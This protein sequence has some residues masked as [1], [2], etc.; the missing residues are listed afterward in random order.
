MIDPDHLPAMVGIPAL[1]AYATIPALCVL[2]LTALFGLNDVRAQPWR[3][4]LTW[5][6]IIE[7]MLGLFFFGLLVSSTHMLIAC[8]AGLPVLSYRGFSIITSCA[9]VFAFVGV[10]A[11]WRRWLQ[12]LA[13]RAAM[14]AVA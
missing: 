5:A 9:G 14:D 6:G 12:T 13:V 3:K 1:Y 7:F 2:W 10:F 11:P 4:T 8:I